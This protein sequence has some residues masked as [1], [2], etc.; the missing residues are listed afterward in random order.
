MIALL[1]IY[2]L[3]GFLTAMGYMIAYV[4]DA[5]EWVDSPVEMAMGMILFGILS[6]GFGAIW[7]LSLP[8]GVYVLKRHS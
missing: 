5:A 7:P 8:I 6:I 2:I 1:L 4:T 3:I